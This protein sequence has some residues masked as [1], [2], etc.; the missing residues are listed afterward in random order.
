[1]SIALCDP[2]EDGQKIETDSRQFEAYRQPKTTKT[3]KKRNAQIV[4]IFLV[5]VRAWRRTG[6]VHD[7]CTPSPCNMQFWRLRQLTDSRLP[8][9]RSSE[10]SSSSTFLN[11]RLKLWQKQLSRVAEDPQAPSFSVRPMTRCKKKNR[12]HIWGLCWL[13]IRQKLISYQAQ[14]VNLVK[15]IC[16]TLKPYL[17]LRGVESCPI[18]C[19]HK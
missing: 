17:L 8:C 5:I 11:I 15:N 16:S 19:A 7:G 12:V 3:K 1:M 6:Q 4:N 2:N 10:W 13:V 14:T 18:T 9:P